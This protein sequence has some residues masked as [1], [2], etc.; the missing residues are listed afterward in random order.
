[1]NTALVDRENFELWLGKPLALLIDTEHSGFA[2]A[3]IAFPVLERYLRGKSRSEPN[4]P[5]FDAALLSVIPELGTIQAAGKFWSIYRHS[6]LHWAAFQK[7]NY[8]FTECP[9]VISVTEEGFVWLNPRLFGGRVL[10]TVRA[11]FE[12]FEAENVPLP[13]V[14]NLE[15]SLEAVPPYSPYLGTSAPPRRRR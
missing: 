14:R 4:T 13:R 9:G 6:L 5:T 2:V 12:P 10:E 7:A 3:M 8:G 11:D 1:M 15:S